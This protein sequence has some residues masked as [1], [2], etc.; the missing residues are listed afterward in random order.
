[1]QYHINI[2]SLT[3]VLLFINI[4][5]S[6]S[7]PLSGKLT[8][9]QNASMLNSE[10]NDFAPSWNKYRHELFYSS[11]RSGKSLFYIS[12][13]GK[14][15]GFAKPALIK[16]SLNDPKSNRSY[17]TFASDKLAYLTS[18]RQTSGYPV[19]N[20]HYTKFNKQVW[21]SP[22]AFAPLLSDDFSAQPAISPD[23]LMMIFASDRLSED[24]LS[25]DGLAK[26]GDTDLWMIEKQ[27]D[28]SWNNLQALDNINSPGNEITPFLASGD[29]LYFASDGQGGPGGFDLFMSVLSDGEWQRPEPM[30]QINTEY[31]ESGLT[32]LPDN[33]LM[34]VSDRPGGKGKLDLYYSSFVGDEASSEVLPELEISLNLT[35]KSVKSKNVYSYQLLPVSPYIFYSHGFEKLFKITAPQ[36]ERL[37][38]AQ[39]INIDS[40]YKYSPA[41]I[42]QRLKESPRSELLIYSWKSPDAELSDE[43]NSYADDVFKFFTVSQGIDQSRIA[44][45]NQ[46]LTRADNSNN[47][48]VHLI[49]FDP[50][51][52]APIEVR[53][54]SIILSPSDFEINIAV[55]PAGIIKSWECFLQFDAGEKVMIAEG[56]QIPNVINID[57]TKYAS[58][59]AYS[60]S[61]IIGF[62]CN[63]KYGRSRTKG[64]MMPVV[65][66]E[67]KS[68]RSIKIG[69]NRY[70]EYYVFIASPQH[71]ETGKPYDSLFDLLKSAMIANNKIIIQYFDDNSLNNAE[72]LAGK[73]A[74]VMDWDKNDIG[75]SYQKYSAGLPFDEK[76][77][78]VIIRILKEKTH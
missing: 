8:E 33:M 38:S 20:I 39:L 17:I 66:S 44:I 30:Y 62:Y 15:T 63:D 13:I 65:H 61:L 1:M 68:K 21:N 67:I 47:S 10:S 18:I 9:P 28:G 54:D 34:F 56:V 14:E 48:Y 43:Q 58:E 31:N 77:K 36:S 27:E 75:V 37:S 7:K 16:S 12:T 25:K 57:L 41:I 46:N 45:G 78:S 51:I 60:D 32:I 50:K 74:N 72:A 76:F 4:G 73:I 59:I 5:I 55:R 64:L 26:D 69:G 53:Q 71:I 70:E 19:A 29:T 49:S 2:L 23:A 42:S 35:V 11:D 24:G 52:F 6:N 3:L 40:I 22:I